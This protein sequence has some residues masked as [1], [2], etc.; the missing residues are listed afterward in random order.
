VFAYDVV[1]YEGQPV[2]QAHPDRL[3][4]LGF[5]HGMSPAPIERARVLELGCGDGAHLVPVAITHPGCECIGIDLSESAIARGRERAAKLGLTNLR[6]ERRDILEI[7]PDVGEFD[8]IISHG[9]YSWVPKPVRDR[10]MAIARERLAPQ[11]VAYIDYNAYPGCHLRMMLRDMLL[12]QTDGIED[13]KLK[14]QHTYALLNLLAQSPRTVLAEE[15]RQARERAGWQL[16]HDDLGEVFHPVYFAQF[17]QHA[18]AHGLQ[19]LAEA[20]YPTQ[21]LF[22]LPAEMAD[23]I[24]M[25]SGDD[26]VLQQQYLDFVE[27]RRFRHTLLCREEIALERPPDARR[28]KDLYIASKA[29]RT[30][31]NEFR[32][33]R[34]ASMKTDLDYA[35][36]A[37]AYLSERQPAAVPFAELAAAVSTDED[38]LAQFLLGTFAAGMVEL[39]TEPSR[40]TI[41]PGEQPRAFS[42]ARLEAAEGD[43]IITSMR[44]HCIELH[45]D[46][47]RRALVLLDGTRNRE[48]LAR[49]LGGDVEANLARLARLALIES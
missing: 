25:V 24:R 28:I 38:T 15:A 9:V 34:G 11:G 39:H 30:G 8:Y 19:F 5:L 36:A 43:Q 42:L 22:A 20:Q 40:F 44:H 2:A 18:R 48:E 4:V 3:A 1:A 32:G 41:T 7:G 46:A 10:L 16:F 45:D 13:P 35:L 27:L 23:T 29:E 6:L 21:Q 17:M 47:A 49:E 31:P 37:I 14:L 26:I 33:P 12:F